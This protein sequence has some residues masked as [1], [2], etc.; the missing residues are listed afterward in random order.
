M[1]YVNLHCDFGY[2]TL[3]ILSLHVRFFFLKKWRPQTFDFLSFLINLL[4]FSFERN[5]DVLKWKNPCSFLNKCINFSKNE[6]ESKIE[7]TTHTSREWTLCFS[8]NKNLK[9][10]SK[11]WWIGARERKKRCIFCNVYFVLK[12]FFNICVLSQ[13]MFLNKLSKYRYFYISKIISS[14]TFVACF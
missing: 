4:Y 5:Y 2:V 8:S 11:P 13:Y 10:K 9:L 1:Q 12:N 14:Y 7:N 3:S 6:T